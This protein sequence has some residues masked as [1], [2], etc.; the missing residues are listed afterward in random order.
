M[1]GLEIKRNGK[2]E[3]SDLTHDDQIFSYLM[4][5]YVWYEGKNLR[6]TFGIEKTTI[7]TED[8]VDD[9]VSLE[10]S[11]DFG[12]IS[13]EILYITRD[14]ED[15]LAA[16]LVDIQKAKGVM[17]N[18]FIERQRMKENKMLKQMLM[19]NKSAREAYA[20]YYNI[21]VDSIAVD[22]EDISGNSDGRLPD[23]LFTDFN[24]DYDELGYNSVYSSYNDRVDK[25]GI[26]T[27]KD[28]E[29]H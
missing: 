15:K 7:K 5:L 26:Y 29:I 25:N 18:E 8:S 16:Q 20:K 22:Q 2:V 24:K 3:H 11:E 10:G 23:S 17:Y 1:R 13:Q 21:S 14:G 19:N 6:E 9:I 4:A 12:D 27:A 28:D